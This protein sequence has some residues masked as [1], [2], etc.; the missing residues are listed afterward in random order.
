RGDGRRRI[1]LDH[2]AERIRRAPRLA[3]GEKAR[4]DVEQRVVGQVVT[5]PPFVDLVDHVVF[6]HARPRGAHIRE[7]R[8]FFLAAYSSAVMAP[9]SRRPLSL[10]SSAYGSG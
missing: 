1:S 8:S 7:S 9:E 5:R 2:V 3:H 6:V 4:A 10:P